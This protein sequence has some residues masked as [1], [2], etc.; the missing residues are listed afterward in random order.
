MPHFVAR[1]LE[2]SEVEGRTHLG[3]P[4]GVYSDWAG[5]TCGLWGTLISGSSGSHL[6][7]PNAALPSSVTVLG[8]PFL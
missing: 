1:E 7:A 3:W 5:G 4:A 2:L 8:I 6:S